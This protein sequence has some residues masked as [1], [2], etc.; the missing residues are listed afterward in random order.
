MLFRERHRLRVKLDR[1]VVA[2]PELRHE[3]EIAKVHH[4]AL[5][6]AETAVDLEGFSKVAG[7]LVVAAHVL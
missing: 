7:R 5:R 6:I 1:L 2:P 4:L 3:P